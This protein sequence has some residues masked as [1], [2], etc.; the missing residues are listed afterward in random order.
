MPFSMSYLVMI[1][2]MLMV[3]AP[4]AGAQ[5]DVDDARDN[6]LGA[7]EVQRDLPGI[8]VREI[9]EV[10]DAL[11]KPETDDSDSPNWLDN[12]KALGPVVKALFLVGAVVAIGFIIW[13][14][15]QHQLRQMKK[16]SV[17]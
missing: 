13:K 3:F 8:D 6:A 16:E 5:S 2:M 4:N 14:L 7:Y 10:E 9:D 1:L 17:T 11:N 12:L 15:L